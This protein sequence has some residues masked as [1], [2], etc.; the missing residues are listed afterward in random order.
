MTG[1]SLVHLSVVDGVARITLDRARRHNSLVPELVE[2]L[3]AAL[4]RLAVA[5]PRLV[6][7]AGA[8]RSFSTG[9]DVAAFADEAI[10][11]R[12]AY[13][14]RLVGG[15][16]AAILDLVALPCPVI[17]RLHGAVTGGSVGLIL[18]CDLVAMSRSAFFAPYYATVGFTPDGGWT[19]LMEP[20]IGRARAAEI[21]MLDRHVG[22]D[23]ALA[24]G[25]VH[26]LEEGDEVDARI[27][28]WRERLLALSPES[29]AATKAL[30]WSKDA[31]DALAERLDRERAAFV[32]N[33]ATPE[34][35]RS[36]RTFLGR[37]A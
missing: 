3:R 22:A 28:V 11:G 29:L 24:L 16:H 8:G 30:L 35:E 19:A 26:A 17:G 31:R 12:A 6:I 33:I 13:A 2:A 25:L 1:A 36:M 37:T 7:L 5:P 14:E 18:A 32:A 15:L 21:L 27:A 10:E 4:A 9:G 34:T 20:R 23:E